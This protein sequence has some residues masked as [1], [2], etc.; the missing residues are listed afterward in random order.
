MKVKTK[1]DVLAELKRLGLNRY[2][3]RVQRLEHEE[4]CEEHELEAWMVRMGCDLTIAE[5]R[6]IK[7]R[8][9]YID[10]GMERTRAKL[11]R[12]SGDT[13]HA[14]LLALGSAAIV[15]VY[16]AVVL[17]LVVGLSG[18]SVHGWEIT[19]AQEACAEHGGVDYIDVTGIAM[20]NSGHSAGLMRKGHVSKT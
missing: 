4:S 19:V 5:I 14:I 3:V 20:C 11:F 13:A 15:V 9:C 2:R 6:Q 17:A 7:F 1:P 8:R 10:R 18:C 16:G 12:L